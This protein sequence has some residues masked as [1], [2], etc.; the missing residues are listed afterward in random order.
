MFTNFI[1]TDASPDSCDQVNQNENELACIVCKKTFS[2]SGRFQL[3][4]V[5]KHSVRND[6]SIEK[7]F[8][9]DKCEKSYTT[10]ANLKHH[11]QSHSGI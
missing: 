9:C 11:K 7:Q 3:H 8:R 4:L 1:P 2:S 5:K 6:Q 10:Q